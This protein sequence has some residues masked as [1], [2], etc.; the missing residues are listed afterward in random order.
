MIPLSELYYSG[1]VY[2][3]FIAITALIFELIIYVIM[4]QIFEFEKIPGLAAL[5]IRITSIYFYIFM[6]FNPE[7]F[8]LLMLTIFSGSGDLVLSE[9]LFSGRVAP[10]SELYADKKEIMFRI[11]WGLGHIAIFVIFI[12]GFRDSWSRKTALRAVSKER[13]FEYELSYD[14]IYKNSISAGLTNVFNSIDKYPV[15]WALP[16]FVFFAMADFSSFAASPLF[17]YNAISVFDTFRFLSSD[18]I[19]LETFAWWWIFC[20]IIVYL[21]DFDNFSSFFKSVREWLSNPFLEDNLV[22]ILFVFFFLVVSPLFWII[23]DN[24]SLNSFIGLTALENSWIVTGLGKFIVFNV[25]PLAFIYF[26]KRGSELEYIMS[27]FITVC[28]ISI[29]FLGLVLNHHNLVIDGDSHDLFVTFD[30][31]NY[32]GLGEHE[33][34][35]IGYDYIALL[36]CLMTC[37]VFSIV[38]FFSLFSNLRYKIFYFSCLFYL[39]VFVLLTFLSLNL[40]TFYMAFEATIIPIGLLITQWGSSDKRYFAARQYVLYSIVSGLPLLAAL[41]HLYNLFGTLDYVFVLNNLFHLS[42]NEQL[43]IWFSFFL[44]FAVKIPLFPFHSWLLNAHVEASTGVSIILAAVLL[45][46][47]T[48]GFIRYL[49]GLFHLISIEYS[50]IVCFMALFGF[51]YASFCA[52]TEVDLK[53][54]IAFTSVA[55]MNFAVIGLFMFD[56]SAFYG[57]V[58]TMF[59]HSIIS[60]ALFFIVGVLYSRTHV[61]EIIVYG[62]MVQLMPILSSFLFFFAIANAGFPCSVSF[63]GEVFLFLAIFKKFGLLFIFLV[64]FSSLL[65]LFA[66]LRL[67]IYV[68]FGTIND[69]FISPAIS[70]FGHIELLICLILF[71]NAFLLFIR[72]DHFLFPVFFDYLARYFS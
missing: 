18:F 17:L 45:K 59:A 71:L 41:G 61:R 53:R 7:I 12:Q 36:L 68:A 44:V 31:L 69:N 11:F 60:T 40:F 50:P 54:L 64:C 33:L 47:G 39:L 70:D 32:V 23:T 15:C 25:F 55:H 51:V 21:G 42:Y 6:L 2:F 19:F 62:G 9:D 48:F 30:V 5:T 29:F 3:F 20:G 56:E 57:A 24:E 58:I 35:L 72:F 38:M 13:P 52:I 66:N 10:D 43:F 34:F 63:I 1:N 14:Y 46:I 27:I 4:V 49:L 37:C 28:G 22:K 65:L 67:F 16:L 26:F 8:D